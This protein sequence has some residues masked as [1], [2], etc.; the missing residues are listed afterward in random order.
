MMTS[1]AERIR[2]ELSDYKLEKDVLVHIDEWLK[3]DKDFNTWFL[4]TTKRALADDELM[5]LLDGYRESQEIIEAAWADFADR[6][7]DT[8]L[9]EAITQ[10]IHRMKLLQNDL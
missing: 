10:S 8:M 3:A 6:R 9:R 4:V 5:A 2:S 1:F 7:D